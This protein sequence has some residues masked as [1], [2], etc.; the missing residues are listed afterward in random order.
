MHVYDYCK[1]QKIAEYLPGKPKLENDLEMRRHP[2][3]NISYQ[4]TSEC[5]IFFHQPLPNIIY[6]F[7][8]ALNIFPSQYL[9]IK[10]LYNYLPTDIACHNSIPAPSRGKMQK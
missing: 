8:L 5:H 9:A 10:Y 7:D 4:A 2:L 3:L 1:C 6:I